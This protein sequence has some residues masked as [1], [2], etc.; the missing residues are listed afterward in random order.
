MKLVA[1]KKRE[2]NQE[3]ARVVARF[4]TLWQTG[5]RDSYFNCIQTEVYFWKFSFIAN[6]V[7]SWK[8]VMQSVLREEPS[9]HIQKL[10]SKW[11]KRLD[12]LSYFKETQVHKGHWF[13]MVIM[14]LHC[15]D[16]FWNSLSKSMHRLGAGLCSELV[17]YKFTVTVDQKVPL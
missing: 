3:K 7:C 14:D 5:Q 4:R 2:V 9:S 6:L 10:K 13:Q 8:N 12:V 1:V 15:S 16:S 11:G 17:Q